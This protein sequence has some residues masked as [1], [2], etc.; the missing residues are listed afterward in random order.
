MFSF[1]SYADEEVKI[2][3]DVELRSLA[4]E[5]FMSENGGNFRILHI[6]PVY[7]DQVMVQYETK[8][9]KPQTKH[10]FYRT[11]ELQPAS[12]EDERYGCCFVH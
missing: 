6:E 10:R 12:H 8:G 2:M 11:S 4:R 7:P 5:R 9:Q 3:D 1:Y